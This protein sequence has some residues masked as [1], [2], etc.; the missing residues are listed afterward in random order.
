MLSYLMVIPYDT[1]SGSSKM[2]T[3]CGARHIF[4]DRVRR[5][6]AVPG[7]EPN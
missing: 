5:A 4:N 3:Y 7:S 2:R 1:E 6:Q